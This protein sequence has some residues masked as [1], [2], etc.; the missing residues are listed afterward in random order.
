MAYQRLSDPDCCESS[1]ASDAVTDLL[2][3]L[4]HLCPI[5]GTDFDALLAAARGQLANESVKSLF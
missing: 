5:I 4:M 2:T 1:A 3:N